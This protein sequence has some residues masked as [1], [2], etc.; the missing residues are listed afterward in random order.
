MN[1][2]ERIFSLLE[3]EQNDRNQKNYSKSYEHSLKIVSKS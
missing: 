2:D 1:Q 3:L